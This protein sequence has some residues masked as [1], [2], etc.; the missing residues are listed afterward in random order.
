VSEH[1]RRKGGQ[2]SKPTVR[3]QM[4]HERVVWIQ[5]L[6][7][8]ECQEFVSAGSHINLSYH[9]LMAYSARPKHSSDENITF[10]PIELLS[11]QE[12][13][14][15]IAG[16]GLN[17]GNDDG[18][19]YRVAEPDAQKCPSEDATED[20]QEDHLGARELDYCIQKSVRESSFGLWDEPCQVFVCKMDLLRNDVVRISRPSKT[21]S[22][23]FRVEIDPLCRS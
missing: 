5:F 12:R 11:H 1:R 10:I 4:G 22:F 6:L 16:D 20:G 13:V 8:L 14:K 3:W 19:S 15:D 2:G 23:K 17:I 9:T 18:P 21:L 7:F